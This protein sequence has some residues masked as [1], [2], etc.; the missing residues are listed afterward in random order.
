MNSPA[1]LRSVIMLS[2]AHPLRGGIASSSERLAQELQAAGYSVTIYSFSFQYPDFLFPG[3]TQYTADPPP[4]GLDI[5]TCVNA[6]QP[7]NWW[8]VGRE[9]ADRRP[10]LLVVRYWLPVMAPALGTICRLASRNG[11]TRVIALADN[12]IPH[13]RRSGDR[14]LTRY[15]IGSVDGFI[16]MSRSVGEEV[17]QFTATKPVTYV[18]HPVYDNYG[19]KADR[20]EA[21]DRL[22]L[23]ADR[24]YLLFFGF[25]RRYKG[26]DL[27]LRALADEALRGQAL[28]LLVAG[29]FYEDEET[30]R[31]LVEELGIAD[32]VIFHADYIPAEAVRDYFAAADLVVQPYRTATQSGISQLAYHFERPMIVTRVGGLPEIVEH[33][34]AGYVVDVDPA[35]VAAAIADFFEYDRLEELSEGVRTGKKRFSWKR[36]VEGLEEM[37]AKL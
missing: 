28:Y 31:T 33:G 20:E 9:L 4:P 10:D 14:L 22:G 3:K 11:H 23:P 8:S 16:V 32:R 25:V 6:V 34:S 12:I 21:L 13:E 5:V 7:Y 26:L 19:P 15:F 29:E 1:P 36:L 17:R 37:Y 18:P 2:P 35:A 30:Y 27:L 24:R